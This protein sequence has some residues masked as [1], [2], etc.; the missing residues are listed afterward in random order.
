ME[1]APDTVADDLNNLRSQVNR[2]I[3][4]TMGG[5]WYDDAPTVNTKKRG[6]L[7]LNTDLDDIEE[8]RF[9][10]RTQILTDVT[11]TASQNWEVLSV[12]GSEAPTQTAAVGAVTTEG[13][14]VAAHTGSFGTA[15]ALMKLRD[16]AQS[17]R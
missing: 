4:A 9:L 7:Q 17:G 14:V 15:H 10:F 8:H 5:N 16:R 13:A 3:D 2:V 6:L 12:S 1:S 11:V